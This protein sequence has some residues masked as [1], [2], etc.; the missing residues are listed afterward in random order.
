MQYIEIEAVGVRVGRGRIHMGAMRLLQSRVG[1]HSMSR[2]L[3][4]AREIRTEGIV[5]VKN[6]RIMNI[7][8]CYCIGVG[9]H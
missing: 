9:A 3:V 6:Q 4:T 8:D 5:K 7:I 2:A 1:C